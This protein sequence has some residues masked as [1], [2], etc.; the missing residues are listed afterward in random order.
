M[1]SSTTR[2][3][4]DRHTPP[5]VR[6]LT[7]LLLCSF[8]LLLPVLFCSCA[9]LVLLG[10]FHLP[11]PVYLVCVFPWFRCRLVFVPSCLTLQPVSPVLS[12]FVCS[13]FLLWTGPSGKDWV[14]IKILF[15][16]S[17]KF[18]VIAPVLTAGSHDGLL[19]STLKGRQQVLIDLIGSAT[20]GQL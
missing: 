11:P 4:K 2:Y 10:G 5:R 20:E 6:G 19:P 3:N 8:H 14:C 9:P 13:C 7:V 17:I 16:L 12:G 15:L 18:P 1:T